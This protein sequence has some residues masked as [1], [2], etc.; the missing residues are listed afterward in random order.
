[1][2][3]IER[4]VFAVHQVDRFREGRVSESYRY[5][6]FSSNFLGTTPEE[7][8]GLVQKIIIS[9]L[10]KQALIK[11]LRATPVILIK[12]DLSPKTYQKIEDGNIENIYQL[13]RSIH[14]R[15]NGNV[16]SRISGIGQKNGT[17]I[18]NA[19]EKHGLWVNLHTERWE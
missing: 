9:L 14:R 10:D 2:K 4:D 3:E 19:L 13:R 5:T 6:A 1:M 7:L 11:K 15:Y 16:L 12:D 17:E 8:D 18:I